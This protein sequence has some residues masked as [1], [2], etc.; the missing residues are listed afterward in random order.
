MRG[1]VKVGIKFRV[2]MFTEIEGGRTETT[3]DEIAADTSGETS[4]ESSF[5]S[6]DKSST[7]EDYH[8]I[9]SYIGNGGPDEEVN[10][11]F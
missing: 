5:S 4:C 7:E 10:H 8:R 6:A 1:G 11:G 3:A 9:K 2:A